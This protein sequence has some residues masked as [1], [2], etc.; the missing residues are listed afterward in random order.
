MTDYQRG[1]GSSGTMM[2]RDTGTVVEFW[3]NSNNSS[4]WNAAL[5]WG[6]TVNGSTGSSTFNYQ[7]GAGWKKLGSFNVGTTQTVTFRIG[8]TGTS[9]FGGPTSF[10]VGISRGGVPGVT[11]PPTFSSI[12]QNSVVVTF[13]D[14]SNGGSPIDNHQIIWGTSP[15]LEEFT[16]NAGFTGS[17]NVTGLETATTYYFWG[18]THN[19]HGWGPWSARSQV[20][21]AGVPEAPSNPVLSEISPTSM[22]VTYSLNGNGGAPFTAFQIAWSTDSGDDPTTATTTFS[23][24]PATILGLT[25]GTI[26]YVWVR[27]A[28]VYGWGPWAGPSS[29]P[30]VSGARIKVGS[31]EKFGIPFVKDGGVWKHAIP[32]VKSVGEWK[33]TV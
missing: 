12:T 33:G 31:V 30:T 11:G 18:R 23:P 6:W 24:S 29:A 17:V 16:D 1:T 7:P 2:I 14:G 22:K 25:P 8:D 15:V 13:V 19:V 4:T 5:P 20:R 32:Y 3:L 26:Y 28:N 21:T 9:G 27:A 10:S